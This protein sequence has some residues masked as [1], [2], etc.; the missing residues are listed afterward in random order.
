MSQN[1][2]KNIIIVFLS[3]FVFFCLFTV[4][5][6][7]NIP[8]LNVDGV[9]VD[10]IR[11]KDSFKNRLV[12]GSFIL[13][14]GDTAHINLQVDV[15]PENATDLAQSFYS[16]NIDVATVTA[17]GVLNANKEGESEIT[18]MV[19]G[20]EA[21]F[22]LKVLAKIVIPATSIEFALDN[23]NV[24]LGMEYNLINQLVIKPLEANDGVD[25]ISSDPT[26]L[27]IDDNGIAT[28]LKE[29]TVTVT[30]SSKANPEISAST[31]VTVSRFEGDYDRVS[32]TMT[33]SQDPATQWTTTEEGNS[34]LAALDG[35]S[36]TNFCLI[37]PGQTWGGVTIPSDEPLWFTIDMKIQQPVSYFRIKHRAQNFTGLRW[38]GFEKI[39]GSNDGQNFEEIAT[40][41][42]VPGWDLADSY[43]SA[44]IE[45]PAYEKT[46]R[47]IRFY[48]SSAGANEQYFARTDRRSVQ[49]E[50]I[51]L[52]IEWNE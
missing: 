36:A 14:E 38:R 45:I 52:G 40:D 26:V 23:I 13:E 11:L 16:S 33:A 12:D 30:A 31:T 44:N 7:D 35:N 48:A 24:M 18:I 3:V 25:F 17:K 15:F 39:E 43:Q 49:I 46:Y 51:Y 2:K 22:M 34:I 28:G 10:S 27:S 19:G 47:Y 4:G 20:H 8:P 32:W 5:C 21:S 9:P 1:M 6:D 42:F 41:V 37:K 29:G 50:E